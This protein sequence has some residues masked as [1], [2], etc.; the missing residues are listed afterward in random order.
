MKYRKENDCYL[1]VLDRGDELISSLTEMVKKEGIRG[2]TVRGLGGVTN[3]T[4][5]FFDTQKKEY[6]RML[7]LAILG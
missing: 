1:A 7:C 3:V 6:L 4:L 5:G 2:G